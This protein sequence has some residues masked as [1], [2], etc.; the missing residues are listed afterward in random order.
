MAA[1]KLLLAVT[2]I[3]SGV[4]IYSDAFI[5]HHRHRAGLRLQQQR[6]TH[7]DRLPPATATALTTECESTMDAAE[8]KSFTEKLLGRLHRNDTTPVVVEGYVTSKRTIGK[9]LAFLDFQVDHD[10][11]GE[12]DSDHNLCQALLRSDIYDGPCHDGYRRCL[13]KGCK[14]RLTGVASST[15]I[16]GN[17]VLMLTS[18]ELLALPH[19]S[20]HIQIVLKLATEGDLPFDEVVRACSPAQK[21]HGD[22]DQSIRLELEEC[23]RLSLSP[24]STDGDKDDPL[25]EMAG[26]KRVSR[27]LKRISKEIFAALPHDPQYPVEADQ[28]ALSKEGNF[29]VPPVPSKWQKVPELLQSEIEK[30]KHAKGDPTGIMANVEEERSVKETLSEITKTTKR[31]GLHMGDPTMRVSVTAWVQNR[32]RF[33]GNVTVFYLVDDMDNQ[34]FQNQNP[35]QGNIMTDSLDRLPCLLHPD[36]LS[37]NG[38][39]DSNMYQNLIA[40]G[41]KVRIEGLTVHSDVDKNNNKNNGNEDKGG[42][43]EKQASAPLLWVQSIRLVRSTFRSVTIRHLLDLLFEKRI[44]PSEASEALLIPYEEAK[45]LSLQSDATERQWKANLLAVQLQKELSSNSKTIGR[46]DPLLLEVMEK[47]RYLSKIHPVIATGIDDEITT[48][49]DDSNSDRVK[50]DALEMSLGENVNSKNVQSNGHNNL[51]RGPRGMPGSKWQIK[52]KPQ[53]EWMSRQIQ[54]VLESHP[55]FKKRELTIL[56]IGGGKGQL[57]NHLGTKLGQ[58]VRVHVVDICQGAVMNGK[59]KAKRLDL[60]VDFQFADASNSNLLDAVDADVVVALH[61]CGHLSD[62]ALNHAIH[63]R[64]GFVIVPCCFNSNPHLMIPVSKKNT[65]TKVQDWLGLPPGDWS[66]LK[67]LAEVQDNIPLASEAIGIICAIRAQAAKNK[68]AMEKKDDSNESAASRVVDQDREITIKSFPIQY[69]TRNTVLIGKC[70]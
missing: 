60:P 57:A 45:Q 68:M 6:T 63:R 20:Q 37:K 67:L 38:L 12:K 34:S 7:A 42:N 24:R 18:M 3:F 35:L 66:A 53:L 41:S 30:S 19:Q 55:D 49:D 59:K 2:G 64:A 10:G 26:R 29:M 62:V 52:K 51:K 17:V 70:S 14:F 47:Y 28:R 23:R 54:M 8:R 13:L 27:R 15:R 1:I 65:L 22:R 44:D 48:G 5:F 50:R 56:D 39:H 36:A 58:H 43:E 31:D 69:S 4:Y 16:P 25:A 21:N 33:Q 40:S 46:V 11:S 61:A 9:N 32:R